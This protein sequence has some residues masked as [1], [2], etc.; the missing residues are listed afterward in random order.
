M[1]SIFSQLLKFPSAF[2]CNAKWK[3]QFYFYRNGKTKLG[4][5]IKCLF[6]GINILLNIQWLN[7][8]QNLSFVSTTTEV[9]HL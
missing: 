5:N 3:K 1:Q 9:T 6:P 4:I 7:T 8:L 2:Y